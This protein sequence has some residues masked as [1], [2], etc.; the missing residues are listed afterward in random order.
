MSRPAIFRD[1]LNVS[2][3][4]LGQ[5]PISGSFINGPAAL[6]QAGEELAE[7][8]CLRNG[9]LAFGSALHV[10]PIVGD[11]KVMDLTRWNEEALWRSTFC[12]MADGCYFFAEDAF[13]TQFCIT[14]RGVHLFQSE[15][16]ELEFLGRTLRDWAERLMAEHR[17]LTG[18]PLARDWQKKFGPLELGRRL[19]PI[20][21]FVLGGEYAVSNLRD[22][23]AVK[24]M[25]FYGDLACQIRE[26]PD[27]TAINLRTVS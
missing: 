14:E 27:G 1:L 19:I 24:A 10:L 25:R 7:L 15:T 2:S 4:A 5:M 20:V 26:L 11:S 13:G 12:G 6:G 16:G 17:V 22:G 3:D 18:W 23:D 9:F 8:L 21:P